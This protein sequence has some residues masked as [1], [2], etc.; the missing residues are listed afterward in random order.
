MFEAESDPIGDSFVPRE[1][2]R[3]NSW[4]WVKKISYPVWETSLLKN[5]SSTT[6]SNVAKKTRDVQK[7]FLRRIETRLFGKIFLQERWINYLLG[8]RNLGQNLCMSR[9]PNQ[10][11]FCGCRRQLKWSS[12]RNLESFPTK[13]RLVKDEA[14]SVF[15]IPLRYVEKERMKEKK[16]S[17]GTLYKLESKKGSSNRRDLV[18]IAVKWT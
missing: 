14:G 17:I 16:K 2:R 1:D 10:R 12:W 9:R 13:T 8:R 4:P 6:L 7:S 15:S 18:E 3:Q 5:F 11:I